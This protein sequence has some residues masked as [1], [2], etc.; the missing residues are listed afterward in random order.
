MAYW[1]VKWNSREGDKYSSRHCSN[2]LVMLFGFSPV[3]VENLR[4]IGCLHF[5]I[6]QYVLNIERLFVVLQFIET[7]LYFI[8][9][10]KSLY[11]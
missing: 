1:Q 11:A 2:F 5:F 9:R 4:N 8:L 3:V 7:L 6:Q 10:K